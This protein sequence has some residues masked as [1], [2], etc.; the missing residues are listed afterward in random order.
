M[1]LSEAAEWTRGLLRDM[2]SFP[3]PAASVTKHMADSLGKGV[4]SLLLLTCAADNDLLVNA[5]AVYA[6]LAVELFHLATLLH[7]D[8]ID[9]APTRRGLESVPSKFGGK[10]AVL[11]GDYLLCLSLSAAARLTERHAARATREGIGIKY[12]W[13]SQ[14][15]PDAAEICLGEFREWQEKG[16]L[17]LTSRRYLKIIT[18]KTA[19]LFRLAAVIGAAAGG[20]D[21][22]TARRAGLFGRCLGIIFQIID[23][24]KDY[25]GNE[26]AVLKPV[27]HDLAQGVVTLPL[28]LAM[29][30]T[31]SLKQA[32]RAALSHEAACDSLAALVIQAGGVDMA[33][34]TALRYA[35]KA[36]KILGTLYD[37]AKREKLENLLQ[38]AA[39]GANQF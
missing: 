37:G 2:L 6:A 34:E 16:N 20:A 24:C 38:N 3:S 8:V 36:R 22:K 25:T 26:K 9:E 28:I 1:P 21:E 27:R 11:V 4:R 19:Q 14:Y 12:A 39:G 32:A 31:P 35:G 18:G 15:L 5:D 30:R 29:A 7:D 23:D 33:R 13:L 17:D 10:P